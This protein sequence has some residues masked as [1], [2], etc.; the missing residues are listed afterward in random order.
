M[1]NQPEGRVGPDFVR[2]R[3]K[4]IE[5]KHLTGRF[6]PTAICPT[7]DEYLDALVNRSAAARMHRELA[8]A[9]IR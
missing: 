9:A 2:F 7:L 4:L 8:A 5:R 3:G 1:I 6:T